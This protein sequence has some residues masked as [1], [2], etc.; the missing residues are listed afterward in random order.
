M[1]SK[2]PR[3]DRHP[4]IDKTFL[5]QI[6]SHFS[7]NL[8][9]ENSNTGDQI[10]SPKWRQDGRLWVDTLEPQTYTFTSYTRHKGNVLLQLNMGF[11]FQKDNH[12]LI[13]TSTQAIWMA[14]FGA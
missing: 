6:F 9:L 14:S 7:P 12:K 5:A 4:V 3:M 13:M 1:R 2:K 8:S 10:G 11:G